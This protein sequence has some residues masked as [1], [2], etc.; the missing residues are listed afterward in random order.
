MNTLLK[1][2]II[3]IFRRTYIHILINTNM[4]HRIQTIPWNKMKPKHTTILEWLHNLIQLKTH[5]LVRM[6]TLKKWRC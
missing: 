2:L 3:L 5:G 4:L 1:E 6:G